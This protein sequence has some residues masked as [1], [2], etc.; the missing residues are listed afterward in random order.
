LPQFL[1][2]ERKIPLLGSLTYLSAV[3]VGHFFGLI[4]GG[5]L[6]DRL[7]RRAV[8]LIFAAVSAI[9]LY[10]YTQLPLSSAQM[11]L[12]GI[13][14]GFC[15][16]GFYPALMSC[17]NE[18]YS[19][20]CRGQGVGFCYS[21]G[22]AMGGTFPFLVGAATASLSLGTAISVFAISSYAL[23]AV[24]AGLMKESNGSALAA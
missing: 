10:V 16:G 2:A 22:R 5:W 8:L 15:P 13:P 9:T 14:L 23:I 11:F 24:I 4:T 21:F 6:A 7:G 19:T 3:I 1:Q 18:S 17:L 12:L 20:P